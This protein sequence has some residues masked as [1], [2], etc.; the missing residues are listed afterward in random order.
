MRGWGVRIAVRLGV[1]IALLA[2]AAASAGPFDPPA[3]VSSRRSY[4]LAEA[5]PY[6]GFSLRSCQGCLVQVEVY[7]DRITPE[8]IRGIESMRAQVRNN[9]SIDISYYLVLTGRGVKTTGAGTTASWPKGVAFQ[10]DLKAT[11]ARERG[12]AV[13]PT[14]YIK[15]P[16][17]T[18]RILPHEFSDAL[19]QLFP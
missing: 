7:T 13:Y 11:R 2:S 8:V 1:V 5:S 9:R 12:I 16:L 10:P 6:E 19:R 18:A 3:A 17:D 4:S 14:Y 15:T